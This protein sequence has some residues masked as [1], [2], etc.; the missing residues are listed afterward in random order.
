[1][2]EHL[3]D[4]AISAQCYRTAFAG[5]SL[6]TEEELGDTTIKMRPES[7]QIVGIVRHATTGDALVL[8]TRDLQV[9]SRPPY[10]VYAIELRTTPTEMNAPEGWELRRRALQVAIWAIEDR[11]GGAL[12]NDEYRTYK[13]EIL[14][15]DHEIFSVP[16]GGVAGS[17]KQSTVGVPAAEIGAAASAKDRALGK[18]H[19]HLTLPWYADQFTGDHAV[20]GHTDRE[21]IGYAIVLS[22]ILQLAVVW[23]AY[24]GRL[25][26]LEAKNLWVVRPRTPP[27][28]ILASFGPHHA[29]EAIA[30]IR[31]AKVPGWAA[32]KTSANIGEVW[33]KARDHIIGSLPMGGH[34]LPDATVNG[35]PAMLFEYRQ[36]PAS[37]YPHAFWA[38]GELTFADFPDDG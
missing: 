21:K 24:P 19:Q 7:S 26:L 8:I 37:E 11:K 32:Q 35:A 28:T 5:P 4:D 38:K 30:A 25:N 17:G 16:T 34:F 2:A 1:M 20:S 18:V 22:A 13:T 10:G 3:N 33:E 14:V 29:E 27:I 15:A 31:T 12:T 6:G 9:A 23:S 36:A